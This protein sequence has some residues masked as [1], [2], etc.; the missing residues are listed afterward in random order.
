[1]KTSF[2]QINLKAF[3][4]LELS[5]VMI[6]MSLLIV[7]TFSAK[8]LLYSAEIGNLVSS[9]NKLESSIGVFV[10]V[11]ETFPG[12][13]VNASSYWND[14]DLYD[15]DG[16]DKIELLEYESTNALIHLQ[17]AQMVQSQG[18]NYNSI[19]EGYEMESFEEGKAIVLSKINNEGSDR[20][21]FEY[22][23]DDGNYI[24]FGG[25]VNYDEAVF[26]PTEM[27]LI[28][29]KIDNGNAKNG[30]MVIKL[31]SEEDNN[32]SDTDGVFT[33]SNE[34]DLCMFLYKIDVLAPE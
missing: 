29:S 17:A 31:N 28:D 14:I 12:D 25:G 3:S 21:G 10:S 24:K 13:M 18:W 30:K 2:D 23:I 1:M 16:D 6:I 22:A 27:Y 9:T 20:D 19:Y 15:G 11:Y 34:D 8:R 32:C 26:T 4:L 7:V 33:T 5:L